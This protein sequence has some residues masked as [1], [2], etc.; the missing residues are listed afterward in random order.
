MFAYD[1]ETANGRVR[2]DMWGEKWVVSY[3]GLLHH[4]PVG[5]D[6]MYRIE[7]WV[8]SVDRNAPAPTRMTGNESVGGLG[9]IVSGLMSSPYFWGG[10]LGLAWRYCS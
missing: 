5:P 4:I 7:S 1:R 3:R 10:L 2:A 8:Q 6:A 9:F